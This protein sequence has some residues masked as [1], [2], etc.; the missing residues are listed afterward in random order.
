M[1]GRPHKRHVQLELPAP[2]VVD[3]N[4]QRRGG[5]RA[6]AGR[7]KITDRRASERHHARPRLRASQPVHVVL[8][9]T[10]AVGSLRT[11][12]VF[13]AIRE[14]T[15]AVFKHETFHIVHLSI[16]RTHIHLLVEA[17][18]RR[19]L[20]TGMQAFGISAA[21]HINRVVS[22]R[23]G[24]RRR[25]AVFTDRYHAVILS[26]PR[27]VRNC[28]AYVMNNWRHHAE[29]A[30]PLRRRWKID[31]YSTALAFDG[32]KEREHTEV[33]MRVPDG[34]DGPLTWL[35]KTWLLREGW[36]RHGL[37]SIYETPGAG[38]E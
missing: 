18:D 22:A 12:E 36:R 7:P 30:R 34:Y 33:R 23:R 17:Q 24:E 11:H 32:W 16:Q 20:A 5:K 29:H 13:R 25:G 38:E 10:A 26:T 3:K 19:A 35:P 15:L 6:G 27:Q 31:P 8:R 28:V 4:G 14:A 2:R 37:V 1:P 21:K 9:A